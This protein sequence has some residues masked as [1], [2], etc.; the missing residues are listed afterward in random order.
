[1]LS[2]PTGVR[3]GVST[4]LLHPYRCCCARSLESRIRISS[5][6]PCW[7]RPAY[8]SRSVYPVRSVQSAFLAARHRDRPHTALPSFHARRHIGWA[9]SILVCAPNDRTIG[10]YI[11]LYWHLPLFIYSTKCYG[12]QGNR[13]TRDPQKCPRSRERQDLI[14]RLERTIRHGRGGDRERPGAL[15]A[16]RTRTIGM[17]SFDARSKGQPRP[18]PLREFG[19]IEKPRSTAARRPTWVPFQE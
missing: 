7:S 5:D 6:F 19:E 11:S 12:W 18:L 4:H 14:I 8:E 1:M 3:P 13:L 16:R 2:V 17:C 9:R 15:L 10:F